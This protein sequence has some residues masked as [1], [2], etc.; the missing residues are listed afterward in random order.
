[1]LESS[2]VSPRNS[3]SGFVEFIVACSWETLTVL[4]TLLQLISIAFSLDLVL[5]FAQSGV[6]DV[7][8]GFGANIGFWSCMLCVWLLRSGRDSR[9]ENFFDVVMLP[10]NRHLE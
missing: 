5:A 3:M 7:F 1:M 10:E 8:A 6:D 2:L 4:L 9:V